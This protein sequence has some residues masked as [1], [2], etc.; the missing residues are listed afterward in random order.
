[1]NPAN[2]DVNDERLQSRAKKMIK[3]MLDK[4]GSISEPL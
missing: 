2:N 3:Q 1:M 4:K